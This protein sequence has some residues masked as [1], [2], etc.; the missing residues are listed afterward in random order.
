MPKGQL[1]LKPGTIHNY[2][3][4]AI[5]TENLTMEDLPAL[6]EQVYEIMKLKIM[7]LDQQNKH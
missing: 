2:F 7:Q 6:K 3:L 5:P 1:G 4:P